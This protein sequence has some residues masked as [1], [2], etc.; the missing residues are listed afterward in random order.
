MKIMTG[1][2]C[3]NIRLHLLV[4]T[5]IDALLLWCVALLVLLNL[6]I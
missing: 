2:E 6:I 3:V 4:A 5:I 1:P